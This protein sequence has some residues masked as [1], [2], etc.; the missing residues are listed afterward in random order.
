MH[1]LQRTHLASLGAILRAHDASGTHEKV[2]DA[3]FLFGLEANLTI[4]TL[5]RH[6]R[7]VEG[8]VIVVKV[9]RWRRQQ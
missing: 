6:P 1:K 8:I 5:F 7:H 4:R 2:L 9:E 3:D